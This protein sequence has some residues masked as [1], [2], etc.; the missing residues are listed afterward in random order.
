MLSNPSRCHFVLDE[1]QYSI[2]IP[3]ESRKIQNRW[4]LFVLLSLNPSIV[5]YR[6]H[7]ANK[8]KIS[9]MLSKELSFA[10]LQDFEFK[11]GSRDEHLYRKSSLLS[12]SDQVQMNEN[13][14]EDYDTATHIDDITTNINNEP[15]LVVN[16]QNH[17]ANDS[18]DVSHSFVN[19]L[20]NP[21]DDDC[22]ETML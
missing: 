5:K 11:G 9:E 7:Q 15:V 21:D 16:K 22:Y 4:H 6:V 18:K 12:N 14:F 3:G 10:G 1:D 19:R 20:F 13:V 17:L 2:D 8:S